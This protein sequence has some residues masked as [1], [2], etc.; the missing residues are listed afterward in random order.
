MKRGNKITYPKGGVSCFNNGTFDDIGDY[1]YWWSSTETD[2]SSAWYRGLYSANGSVG[3][4]VGSKKVGFSL[5]CLR[6]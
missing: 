6:D 4:D 5:R 3:R 1:G 2:A